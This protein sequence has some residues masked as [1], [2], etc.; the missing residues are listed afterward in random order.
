MISKVFIIKSIQVLCVAALIAM[1]MMN[2]LSVQS[3]INGTSVRELSD[4]Y[5]NLFTPAPITFAVWGVI[6]LALT[7][8]VIVQLKSLFSKVAADPIVVVI[9]RVGVLFIFSCFFNSAWLVAWHHE[10]LF[11]SVLLMIGLLLTLIEI[12]RRISFDLPI[13]PQYRLYLKIPF[14]LYLG[15]ISI[16][17]IANI[18][19]YLTKTEWD[20]FGLDPRFWQM[21]M[22]LFGTL[23]T[24]WSV[25][26]L[27][28]VA[29]G[30]VVLWALGGI[31]MVRINDAIPSLS[32]NLLITFCALLILFTTLNRTKYWAV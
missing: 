23:I 8:Y 19:A 27:N 14:G 11:Y 1:L 5:S 26:K 18:A 7:I 10:K 12:N 13:S 2:Y 25:F 24:C 6:Y 20:G 16:A 28:N 32:V 31:L 4:K 9:R 17:I 3:L 30:L 15:W 22:V 21:F 29:Q